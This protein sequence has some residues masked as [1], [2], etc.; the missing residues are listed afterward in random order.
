MVRT[1]QDSERK[2]REMA[3]LLVLLRL[4]KSFRMVQALAEKLEH[5]GPA[6]KKRVASVPQSEQLVSTVS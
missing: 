6:G 3:D 2:R 4:A 1:K 5:T